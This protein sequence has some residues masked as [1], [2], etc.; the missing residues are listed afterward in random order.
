MSEANFVPERLLSLRTRN[1]AAYKGLYALQ[2]KNG[3]ADWLTGDSL[4]IAT[5]MSQT[6]DIHH[7][8]PRAWCERSDPKI[9]PRL[10]NSIINKTPIDTITNRKIG[11]RSPSDYLDGLKSGISEESLGQVLRAHWTNPDYLGSDRFAEFFVDRGEAMLELI[12][13]VMGKNI[14]SG[15]AVFRNALSDAGFVEE[16]EAEE[17]EYDAVGSIAYDEAAD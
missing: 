1:S 17:D 16:Y 15:S 2:M 10:Y 13:R 11:G 9:P 12:G 6:I 7:I 8:F 4:T 3:A 5:W 14:G